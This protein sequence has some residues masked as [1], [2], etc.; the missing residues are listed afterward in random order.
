[1]NDERVLS[2][3]MLCCEATGGPLSNLFAKDCDT[4]ARRDQRWI[5]HDSVGSN[6]TADSL[7]GNGV[8]ATNK[9]VAEG[10]DSSLLRKGDPGKS[11]WPSFLKYRL[12]TF[13]HIGATACTTAT[14]MGYDL[15]LET[16]KARYC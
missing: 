5:A 1:M 15:E 12:A 10:I 4:F 7:I 16:L 3:S 6:G 11:S 13:R 2:L 14:D 8:E 9:S